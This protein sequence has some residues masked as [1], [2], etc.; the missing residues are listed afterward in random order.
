MLIERG[1]ASALSLDSK[2]DDQKSLQSTGP[3]C[4]LSRGAATNIAPQMHSYEYGVG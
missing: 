3:S 1:Q 2:V 4:S